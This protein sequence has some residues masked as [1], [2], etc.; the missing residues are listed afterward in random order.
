MRER[1]NYKIMMNRDAWD[2]EQYGRFRRERK[3]PFFDLLALVR[4]K[5]R[6][7]IVDLGCGPGELTDE[8]HRRLS[9]HEALGIDISEAMLREADG[10][11]GE[12]LS[13]RQQDIAYFA[14]SS[15]GAAYDL[16]FSNAALQ[17]IPDHRELISRL[18]EALAEDG[19]LAIQVPANFDHVSHETASEIAGESPFRE[20]LGGFTHPLFVLQ[21]EAYASLLD[22]LR[23][24]EQHVR[25][26]V[27]SHRL[28]SREEVVEWLKGSLL[29]LYESRLTGELFE[30]FIASYRDR[31][32]P[33]L[34]DGRP[35]FLTFKRI[36][37]W[38]AR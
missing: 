23:Y 33:R 8:L 36:L 16:V 7:R 28:G 5:S 22:E 19:Q 15:E 1:T 2:P 27:Y 11:E 20:A 29:T 38:A 18:T 32:L 37:I 25:L 35:F 14:D 26:Q 9:A 24:R 13:F 6:M 4:P 31:L 10:R 30:R 17:W 3:Q 21:P 12:G 34:R